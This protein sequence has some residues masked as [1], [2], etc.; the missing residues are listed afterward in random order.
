M[1]PLLCNRRTIQDKRLIR[2]QSMNNLTNIFFKEKVAGGQVNF[3]NKNSGTIIDNLSDYSDNKESTYRTHMGKLEYWRSEYIRVPDEFLKKFPEMSYEKA[4]KHYDRY[5]SGIKQVILKRLPYLNTNYIHVSLNKLWY[6]RF[7]YKNQT[8]YIYKEFCDLR[9]FFA[10][11]E[12]KKGNGHKKGND[13]QKNSEVYIFNQK[14]I[15]LL[16]DHGDINELVG[17]YYGELTDNAI[18]TMEFIPIDIKSLNAYIYNT[19]QEIEKTQ[20]N[21]SYETKLYRNLRQAKY[22]RIISE[23]F[24]SVKQQYM[25]PQIPQPSPYGRMYYK[26]IN[27]QNISKEVRSAVLGDYYSYDL[28]A[29]VYAIKLM[30]AKRILTEQGTSDYGLY[31]YTKEYLDKKSAIR[32]KLSEHIKKYPKPEKLVKEALTAIGFGARISGGSW[33]IDGQWHT[34][35]IEDIIM[36]PTERHNFM[37]DPWIKNF[38]SEQR[39]LTKF[40]TKYYI[41]DELINEV[42]DIPNMFGKNGKIRNSQVMS[43]V[44]QHTEKAI[45]DMITQDIPVIA[46][47]HDSFITKQKLSNEQL[48]SIKYKLNSIEPLMTLDF[49]N[50]H[51]WINTEHYDDE[52]DIDMAFSKL[53]GVQHT[54]PN[55]TIDYKYVPKQ[56]DYYDSIMSYEQKEYDEY[57]PFT[58]EDGLD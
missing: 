47:V 1:G 10:V 16:I 14:L 25:L 12:D 11:I 35:S 2:K 49:E 28:N 17:I 18:D 22:I 46:R 34:T 43:Y 38:D 44:F 57:D 56:N 6:D 24:Y 4:Q 58:Y 53:T 55:I 29:A 3:S 54:K 20:K 36:N 19:K 31:T 8:Y 51:A 48:L 50:H 27:I 52:S 9:P 21:S 39:K 7:Y 5:L 32:K 41:N 13:F 40:I 42:Q 15:D 26:G 45:M 33:Q 37:T 30:L 23:F